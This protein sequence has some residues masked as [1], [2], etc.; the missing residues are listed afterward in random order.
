MKSDLPQQF[1]EPL[2]WRKLGLVFGPDGSQPWARHSALQPTPLLLEDRIRIYCGVR[3]DL[4][5]SSVY[6]VDLDRHE[7]R[8]IIEKA[9]EPVLARGAPGSFD[10]DGVVPCAVT[11]V[12]RSLR[13]YYA[14]YRLGATADRRFEAFSGIAESLDGGLSFARVGQV[15]FPCPEAQLFRAIHSIRFERG[16]WRSWYGGGSSFRRGATKTLPVYDIRYFESPDGLSFPDRGEVCIP[17]LPREHRVGRPW[18]VPA[19]GGRWEMFFGGGTEETRYRMAWAW[20]AN[21]VFWHR[22]DSHVGFD[23]SDSGW[24]SAMVAYPA[25]VDVAGRRLL[26]Y[27]GNDY[28]RDGFG[29]A[30]VER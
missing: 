9:A 24:D 5:R 27:N 7:P 30:E 8:R 14:G 19:P 16:R 2:H 4:G 23:V 10:C 18:V 21:G 22:H 15:L 13:M 29:C 20:S 17:L 6:R 28:G 26:F 11:W 1:V 12:G 3:D 25:I